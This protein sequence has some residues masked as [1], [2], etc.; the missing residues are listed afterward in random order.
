[1][2]FLIMCSEKNPLT[3]KWFSVRSEIGS[4]VSKRLTVRVIDQME[5]FPND[6]SP[7]VMMIDIIVR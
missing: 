6:F 7:K 5:F 2:G 3:S 4:P 1:V